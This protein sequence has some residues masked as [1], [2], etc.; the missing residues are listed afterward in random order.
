MCEAAWAA[1]P[2]HCEYEPS[3]PT[4]AAAVKAAASE[5]QGPIDAPPSPPTHVL[6]SQLPQYASDIKLEFRA[7]YRAERSAHSPG[8]YVWDGFLWMDAP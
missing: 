4:Q 3:I 7:K 8:L 2:I 1:N 5:K 6:K